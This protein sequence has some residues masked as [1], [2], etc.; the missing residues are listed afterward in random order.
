MPTFA[1]NKDA[2]A[3]GSSDWVR[4]QAEII[5]N[6]V[7]SPY[8]YS[9]VREVFPDHLV[10]DVGM[11]ELLSMKYSV[12]GS[13]LTLDLE[14]ATPVAV[15]YV[16]KWRGSVLTGPIIY[17]A[18]ADDKQIA[19]AAV[20]VPGEPDSDGDVVSAAKVEEVAH[21]W[22]ASYR[23]IDLMHTLSSADSTPVESYITPADLD[24]GDYTLPA[25]TWVMAAKINDAGIWDAVKNGSLTGFS[26]M[27]VR[28]AELTSAFKNEAALK[29]TLL[30]DLGD[31]WVCPFVSLVD[32]PAVPKAK[33]FA[34]KSAA[35]EQ[36][37]WYH[38]LLGS[39]SSVKVGRK[40]SEATYGKMKDAHTAL[41]DLI[42]EAEKE[43]KDKSDA[44]D[45]QSKAAKSE[46]SEMTP[47]ELQAAL[48]AALT[49]LADRLSAIEEKLA[50]PV[51]T[52]ESDSTEETESDK[53]VTDLEEELAEVKGTLAE[54]EKRLNPAAKSRAARGQDTDVDIAAKEAAEKADNSERDM[55]GRRRTKANN[56]T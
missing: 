36:S 17:K 42:D 43:R 5:L 10:V 35:K 23:N 25:G 2:A 21:E 4:L 53:R 51:E 29:R 6:S 32:A 52:A 16:P 56:L 8:P 40:F 27:G 14:G 48:G 49:P 24:V 33:F 12:D 20:L 45:E 54:V 41:G 1:T 44:K 30:S 38:R 39:E 22:L 11:A 13:M 9:W 46:G 47:E 19:Y 55:F 28:K 26:I 50:A 3:V 15:Q 37:K 34:L 7:D 31:D 18:E